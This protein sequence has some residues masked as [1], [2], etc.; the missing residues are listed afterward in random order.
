MINQ[1]TVRGAWNEISGKLRSKWGQL[2]EDELQ[3]YEGNTTQL[4]GYIQ[5][6]TG[7]AR[8]KI[9]SF[10]DDLMSSGT[11][12]LH[13]AA[14]AAADMASQAVRTVREGA[15]SVMHRAREGFESAER[16]LHDRPV[17]SVAAAFGAGLIT[18]VVVALLLRSHR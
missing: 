17:T 15:D 2:S 16:M 4:V 14:D 11:S 8:D 18:G 9:E 7:E 12:S 5:R 10:V 1:Q 6:K 13:K 3:Q